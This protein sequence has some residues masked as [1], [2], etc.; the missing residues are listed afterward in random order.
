MVRSKNKKSK[1][2]S[3][4]N[5]LPSLPWVG[6]FFDSNYAKRSLIGKLLSYT[7][8][9]IMA[10]YITFLG[11]WIGKSPKQKAKVICVLVLTMVIVFHFKIEDIFIYRYGVCTKAVVTS[12]TPRRGSQYYYY[13]FDVNGDKYIGNSYIYVEDSSRIGDTI[14]IVYLPIFPDICG[15]IEGY[16][17][18]KFRNFVVTPKSNFD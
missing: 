9:F 2:S 8:A 18:G 7:L 5:K 4:D 16:F 1:K 10:F 3:T 17:D 13:S 15:S 11:F 6:R 14:D 12:R